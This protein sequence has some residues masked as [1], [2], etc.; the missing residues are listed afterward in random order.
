LTEAAAA[1]VGCGPTSLRRLLSCF[2]FF[3][4]KIFHHQPFPFPLPHGHGLRARGHAP[5]VV[6]RSIRLAVTSCIAFNPRRGVVIDAASV[7]HGKQHE[8]RQE[9][10]QQQ[11]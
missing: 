9:L 5:P 7:L 2:F 11:Q 10:E 1:A 8:Q 3:F 6:R 4:F